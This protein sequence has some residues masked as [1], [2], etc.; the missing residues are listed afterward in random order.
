MNYRLV[1]DGQLPN[2]YFVSGEND[3]R[4]PNSHSLLITTSEKNN[5]AILFD[6][7]IGHSLIKRILKDFKITKV[8]LSHWHEDHISGNYLL[9]KQGANFFCHPLDAPLLRDVSKFQEFY[10]TAG[11]P[12]AD[13]FQEILSALKIENLTE[14]HKLKNNQE[15]QVGND[16]KIKVLH[17]PGHS[18]GHCCYY[19]PEKRLIYLADIDLTGLGPWYGCLD[20][21]VDDFEKSIRGL[22]EMNIEFAI[23]GHKGLFTGKNEIKKQLKNYL[24]VIYIRDS[25]ILD[26]LSETKPKPIKELIGKGIVYKNYNNEWKEYLLIAENQMIS[27]HVSRLIK[28]KKISKVDDGFL[29]N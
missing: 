25:K 3:G 1:I 18:A 10:D 26:E 24:D 6:S 22:M 16:Q 4:Y 11:S 12:V 23:S 20:S 2:F 9:K 17:T 21:S 28:K 29:L 27:K 13:V 15:V 14:I 7:G 19:E 8:F 5:E